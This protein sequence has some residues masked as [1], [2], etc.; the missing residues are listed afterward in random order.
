MRVLAV[1]LTLGWALCFSGMAWAHASLVSVEPRDG[2]LLTEAPKSVDLHFN[3]AVTAGAVNL[4]DAQ[5][6]L[7]GDAA[8]VSDG[9]TI[10]VVLPPAIPNGTSVVS[11]RVISQDGH[12]VAG[13]VTF[14][15][16][17]PT[18]AIRPEITNVATVV[19]IWLA[20]VASYVGLFGGV[21]GAF[22]LV[23]IARR[24][25]ATRTISAVLA[26]G[27]VGAVLSI[28][29]QGLDVLGLPLSALLSGAPWRVA[30]GTSLG[31]S[32][33]VAIAAMALSF[34]VLRSGS[35]SLARALS[36]LALTG[37]GLALAASGHAASAPPQAL[38]RL[39]IFLHAVAVAFW[40]G[41][42]LPLAMLLVQE[43]SA[44]LPII[45]RFSAVALVV[46]AVLVATGIALAIVQLESLAALVDTRYG[47]ILSI[48]LLLVG[49]LLILAALSRF[50]F[51]PA[52]QRGARAAQPSG[53]AQPLLRSIVAECMLGLG[54]LFAVAGWRFTP[55]PRSLAPEA[56]LA[57]HIHT[58]KAMFQVLIRPGRVGADDF[59]LQLMN[60]D[61]TLLKVK[62]ATMTVSQPS[63]GIEGIERRGVLGPDAF[64]RVNNVPLSVPGRWHIRIDALVTDFEKL[65]LED[66]FDVSE[67]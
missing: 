11:Y 8:T 62:E 26:T 66:D 56:P 22:F 54:I 53:S 16:G 43:R 27:L 6:K 19:L 67:R 4:V 1:A 63:V 18:A 57:I 50:R 39:A 33:L 65:S 41:A 37:A 25:A 15:V 61:G 48:K 17:A 13:S 47:V 31:P 42:L 30:L 40:L 46:V 23:W 52:L 2:S 12:P 51:T 10:K 45:R 20:R 35:M 3:E 28:G 14:S 58:D 34:V 55:P 59:V 29:L 9:T 36:A 21:G 49:V 5:G 60:D 44:A 38:M 24:G 7:R 64:W 32:M